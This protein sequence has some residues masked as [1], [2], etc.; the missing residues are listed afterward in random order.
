MYEIKEQTWDEFKQYV[1]SNE[2]FT[3]KI[4]NSIY[5]NFEIH[6]GKI[7]KSNINICRINDDKHLQVIFNDKSISEY[8]LVNKVENENK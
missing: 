7:K 4:V 1:L 5:D 8:M 3:A 2:D 6:S